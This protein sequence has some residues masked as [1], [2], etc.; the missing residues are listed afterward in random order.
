MNE[1]ET[2]EFSRQIG[3]KANRMIRAK[4]NEKRSIWFGFSMF[5]L[6]GW[7][8]MIPTVLGILLG[9]W[10]DKHHP[11]QYSWTLTFLLIG[12]II[13]ILNAGYWVEKEK[14]EIERESDKSNET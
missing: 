1:H 7:S 12:L 10:I 9:L 11:G 3:A 5:G 4:R 13:G 8:V 14:K 6:V 2:S